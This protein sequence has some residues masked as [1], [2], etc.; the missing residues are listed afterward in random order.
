[1][2]TVV[3]PTTIRK[4]EDFCAFIRSHSGKNCDTW[5]CPM[6]V[7]EHCGSDGVTYTSM[8]EMYYE[9]KCNGNTG[10]HH[11]HHGPCD[12]RKRRSCDI[13]CPFIF[14][15]VCGTNGVTYGNDCAL[16]AAVT[17]GD[18]PKG[19]RMAHEGDC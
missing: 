19:T 15:P 8:C 13:A 4:N 18:A 1:M 12:G 11:V 9:R 3:R 5:R 2:G 17:C 16:N 7:E 6:S 14:A 10:L